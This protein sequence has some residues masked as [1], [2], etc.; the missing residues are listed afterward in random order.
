MPLACLASTTSWTRTRSKHWGLKT[1]IPGSPGGGKNEHRLMNH[2]CGRHP[3]DAHVSRQLR[4]Q[5]SAYKGRENKTG[6]LVFSTAR[7]LDHGITLWRTGC[8]AVVPDQEI[9]ISCAVAGILKDGRVQWGDP[10][11]FNFN[12]V[13]VQNH[14]V[15]HHPSF[16]PAMIQPWVLRPSHGE[17]LSPTRHSPERSWPRSRTVSRSSSTRS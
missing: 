11:Y 14:V 2:L 5:F 10:Q 15:E 1:L 17:A 4:E 16:A 12:R 8:G 3:F 9:P 13:C 7:V 6:A